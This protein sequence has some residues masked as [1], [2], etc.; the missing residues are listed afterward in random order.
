MSGGLAAPSPAHAH[1]ATT[2]AATC[3][4]EE[5]TLVGSP[6][7]DYIS[8]TPQRDVIV[9][10]GSFSVEAE[11]GDDLICI[12]GRTQEVYAGPGA[13]EIHN[14]QP[15]TGSVQVELGTGTDTYVG[16]PGRDEVDALDRYFGPDDR[17]VIQTGGNRDLVATGSWD[18]DM[19]DSIDLG[20][21]R[22]AFTSFSR[23]SAPS[24]SLDGGQGSDEIFLLDGI[25]DQF[26]SAKWEIDNRASAGVARADGVPIL[27]WTSLERFYLEPPVGSL[28]FRGGDA[29]EMLTAPK[30]RSVSMGAG[31]DLVSF[32]SRPREARVSGGS[33]T[34]QLVV[35]STYNRLCRGT[36]TLHLKRATYTCTEPRV[37]VRAT[38]FEGA[39]VE[40]RWVVLTGTRTA[41]RLTAVATCGGVVRAG[42]GRDT[43]TLEPS[44]APCPG[45]PRQPVRV[46]GG[47]GDDEL[48]GGRHAD[49]LLGGAGQDSAD[50]GPGADLCRAERRTRCE[51]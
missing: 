49:V 21:G 2:P 17:D 4:G 5:A 25:D 37:R 50:G 10:N 13:D 34:D 42:Y 16:G 20:P 28:S 15:S 41:N 24:F 26:N 6:S 29:D 8:G 7:R 35:G 32:Y 19:V 30:L 51:R 9:T 12:T 1:A 39:G 18:T 27:A 47:P 45:K 44:I 23:T 36:A 22:D 31:D 48:I 11:G 40:G 38:G 43:V 33:G 14:L 46:L 3:A